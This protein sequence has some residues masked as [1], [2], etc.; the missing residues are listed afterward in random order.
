MASRHGNRPQYRLAVRETAI[1]GRQQSWHQNLVAS[2]GQAVR[3][4]CKKEAVDHTS[5]SQ[6]H[7]CSWRGCD[8]GGDFYRQVAEGGVKTGGD[9]P[10]RFPIHKPSRGGGEEG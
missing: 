9:Q 10:G 8:T 3:E 4:A 6:S 2:F 7:R 5:A 1:S